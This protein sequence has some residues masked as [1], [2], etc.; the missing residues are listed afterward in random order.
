MIRQVALTQD[1]F[2]KLLAWLDADR[3]RAG[4]RYEEIRHSLIKIFTWRGCTEAED[5]A[6]VVINRVA[7][8]V[9]ELIDIYTGDPALYFYGVAKRVLLEYR[10]REKLHVQLP[11]IE[12]YEIAV[13]PEPV[14]DEEMISECLKRC[15]QELSL[16]HRETITNYYLKDK[17]AKI[18]RRKEIAQQMSITTNTLRVRMYR[19]R[20]I[21]EQC[22]KR[23]L[24]QNN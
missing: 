21:L 14:N 20:A 22:I 19:I 9:P 11:E 8:K 6:D 7:E 18:D 24:E 10:K 3:E 1:K 23:C 5:M 15:L 2:D 4:K 16:K 17:Q 13:E 12:S